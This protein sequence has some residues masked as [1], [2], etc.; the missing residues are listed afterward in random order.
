MYPKVTLFYLVKFL[1][2][3]IWEGEVYYKIIRNN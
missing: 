2:V 1:D 3:K